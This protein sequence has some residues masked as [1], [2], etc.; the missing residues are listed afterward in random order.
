MFYTWTFLIE[1]IINIITDSPAD[2]INESEYEAIT[3]FIFCVK[4]V[5][6]SHCSFNLH[7]P[8]WQ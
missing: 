4:Y 6:I 3:I 1:N 8:N 7:F 5:V 2:G